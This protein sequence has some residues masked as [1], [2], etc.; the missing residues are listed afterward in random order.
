MTEFAVSLDKQPKLVRF[1]VL[2][3]TLAGVVLALFYAFKDA[4]INLLGF[5]VTVTNFAITV[6][7]IASIISAFFSYIENGSTEKRK[8][9]I[10]WKSIAE[11]ESRQSEALYSELR[12]LLVNGKGKGYDKEELDSLI[13]QKIEN[14]SES[15]LKAYI[16]NN[17]SEDILKE[18][19]LKQVDFQIR[20]LQAGVN[21]QIGKLSRNGTVNLLIGLL[22]SVTA[23]I[24]LLTLISDVKDRHFTDIKEMLPFLVPR[25]TLAIFIETFSFFFL[26]LYKANLED[27]KYFHNERTNID[28]KIIALKVAMS[29]ENKEALDEVIKSFFNVERNFILKKD[30]TTINVERVKMGSQQDIDLISKF[31]EIIEKVK[32]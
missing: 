21:V 28:S 19:K 25:T 24:V 31:I 11:R 3:A 23:I 26:R 2:L 10:K 16:D 20:E 8:N 17:Y 1:I 9:E 6:I 5:R 18:A 7:V 32:K 14:N 13:N 22:T 29:Y 12:K 15:F 4:E 27:V 30:E